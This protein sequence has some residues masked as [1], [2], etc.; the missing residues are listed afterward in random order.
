MAAGPRLSIVVPLYQERDNI[1]P[2]HRALSEVIGAQ[3]YDAEM[4]F[5]DDGSTD[6]SP[7]VLRELAAA[8]GR[9]RVLRFARNA[10][11]T[12]A[13]DAGIRAAR[14]RTVV[15]MDGDLQNDPQDIPV[16][17]AALAD[18]DCACG[19]RTAARKGGDSGWKAFCSRIANAV[20]DRITGDRVRDSGC[21]FRA[22]RRSCFERIKLYRGLHRFLPT[23]FRLEG[24]SV[25]EVPVGHRPRAAGKSKY[26]ALN[27]MFV[28]LVD[29]LAVAWMRRRMLRYEVAEELPRPPQT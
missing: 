20:R 1:R 16:L 9:V 10:G 28:A 7:A 25:T 4:I 15:T 17:L 8:D 23:L 27:R 11:Q 14:G 3:G 12:A 2:L 29:C 19:D 22:F 26:G 21:C 5:V 18:H 13:L 24:L 6:D